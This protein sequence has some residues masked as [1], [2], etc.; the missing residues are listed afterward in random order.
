MV[1]RGGKVRPALNICHLGMILAIGISALVSP[2]YAGSRPFTIADDIEWSHFGDLY[3]GE[4]APV[5]FSPDRLYF[6]VDTE[7]GSLTVNRPQSTLWVYRTREAQYF[8]LH[9][10][11]RKPPVPMWIIRMSTYEHGPIITHIR[12]TR[13]STKFGFL[14]KSRVGSEQLF[15]ADVESKTV[16]ALTHG[17]QSVL[18]FDIR[19]R[20]HYVY[21]TLS[22]V[23]RETVKRQNHE[24]GLVG[25]GYSLGSLM[26]AMDTT[27]G[28]ISP[29]YDLGELWVVSAGHRFRVNYKGS[30]RPLPLHWAGETM[31]AVGGSLAL[32]P[33]GHSAVVI[34]AVPVIPPE[35]KDLYP[36]PDAGSA[37][38]VRAAGPQ[39]LWALDGFLYSSEY[40]LIDLRTGRIEPLTNAPTGY[41][42]SNWGGLETAA[43]S[44][45]GKAILLSNT[46]IPPGVQGAGFHLNSPCVTVI[47][48]ASR[49]PICLEHIEG[50]TYKSGLQ[51]F[52]T[53][54]AFAS[55]GSGEI[56]VNY[57]LHDGSSGSTTYA[58][59]PDGSWRQKSG[60]YEVSGPRPPVNVAIKEDLNESPVLVVVDTLTKRMRVL[61]D[62]NP[63]LREIDLG[64]ASVV[65]WT[66]KLGRSWEGGLYKPPD[67]T[68]T[69]RYPLV[70]QT[71][72]FSEH[73]FRPSGIYPTGFAARALAAPGILVLQVPDCP[74][75]ETRDEGPCNVA[76]YESGVA[77]LVADRSVDPELVGIT[78][79][80]RTC[81]DVLETLTTAAMHFRAAS[82][83][84]GFNMGYAEYVHY[85]DYGNNFNLHT[86]EAALGLGPPFGKN[87]NEWLSRAPTFNM[88]KVFTPLQVVATSNHESLLE[89]WEPYAE[90]RLLHRPVDLMILGNGTHPLSNPAQLRLSQG[91]LVDWFRFWLQEYEDPDP[92]KIGQYRR[93]HE[94]RKQLEQNR[95]QANRRSY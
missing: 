26:F 1:F 87:L 8:V 78:G 29:W 56:I 66:D 54:A 32:S 92:A 16:V 83:T 39:D 64:R 65:A 13:D 44:Q 22:P 28:Q 74:I 68:P 36:P 51:R 49:H 94:L 33:D 72:G 11:I 93:W 80:S 17:E 62:P 81:F 73:Q 88:D 23:I 47:D 35:W 20:T 18:Q 86:I 63:Q 55:D 25:T 89:M 58:P 90:L 57:L 3:N 41:S 53:N 45:D 71:H 84:D 52:I 12:W 50:T 21:C 34:M 5:T 67:Y 31:S 19:D 61:L 48:V 77:K 91:G 30:Q 70:V 10:E 76:A 24:V 75:F 59:S 46:F 40:V 27:Y 14:A 7:R 9:P 4:I 38:Q 79:F 42:T 82:I 60:T 69:K 15:L 43:W 37:I 2:R 95:D 85:V 6:V